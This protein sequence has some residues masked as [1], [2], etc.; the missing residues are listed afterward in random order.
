MGRHSPTANLEQSPPPFTDVDGIRLA[1]VSLSPDEVDHFYT[2][3]SNQT[4]WPL[5][6]S[7]PDKATISHDSYRIYRDVNRKYADALI[8]SA[9][10]R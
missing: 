9:P 6:H 10:P 3:F 7:F 1:S 5:L 8:R 2:I 4:L